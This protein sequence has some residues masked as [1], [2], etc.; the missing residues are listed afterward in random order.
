MTIQQALFIK[1][2]RVKQNS[3][4]RYVANKYEQRYRDKLPYKDEFMTLGGN[5]IDG[6]FLC[7]DAEKILNEKWEE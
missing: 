7:K 6:M 1:W 5:Q 4:W 2:L 3:S